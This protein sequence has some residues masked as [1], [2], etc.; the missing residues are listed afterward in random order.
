MHFQNFFQFLSR[1]IFRWLHRGILQFFCSCCLCGAIYKTKLSVFR[2]VTE[3][4]SSPKESSLIIFGK[5]LENSQFCF[6]NCSTKTVATE[7]LKYTT[8]QPTEN[9]TRQKLK[10]ISEM[11]SRGYNLHY[12]VG[13]FVIFKKIS[14]QAILFRKFLHK[15]STSRKNEVYHDVAYGKCNKTANSDF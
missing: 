3:N 8:T 4:L 7:K 6:A 12:K 9:A 2:F 15:D 5:N 11:H 1:S 13:V 10:D 14:K